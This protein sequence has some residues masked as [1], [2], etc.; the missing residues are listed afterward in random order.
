MGVVPPEPTGEQ[1]VAALQPRVQRGDAAWLRAA[2]LVFVMNAGS[3]A[4]QAQATRETI[5]RVVAQA[6]RTLRFVLVD[7][8]K[9]LHRCAQEAAQQAQAQN[10][11]LVAVGGD[12]TIN[13]IAAA[14]LAADVP[15]G[16]VPQGTFNFFGRNLGIP[17]ELEPAL[18][19]LLDPCLRSLHLGQVG[20]RDAPARQLFLVSASLGFYPQLIEDR[21]YWKQQLGRRRIVALWSGLMTLLGGHRTLRLSLRDAGGHVKTVKTSTLLVSDNALQMANLGLPEAQAIEDG[22]LAALV[23]RSASRW[24]LLGLALRGALGRL[25]DDEQLERFTFERLEVGVRRFAPGF[26]FKVAVDGEIARYASPLVFEVS[27]QPL[28]VLVPWPH[29]ISAEAREAREASQ[30]W[31]EPPD[32]VPSGAGLA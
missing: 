18:Q 29:A 8:A 25:A 21:E 16:V 9:D 6:G 15:L 23:V 10:G 11:V 5:T 20:E 31:R 12:G 2:P 13:V 1:R 27:P 28:Q 17:T 3:G 4:G 19:T 24:R 32:G 30:A 14:A 26:R 7:D 22:Q